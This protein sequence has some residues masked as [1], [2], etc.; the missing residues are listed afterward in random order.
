[1]WWM[2]FLGEMIKLEYQLFLWGSVFDVLSILSMGRSHESRWGLVQRRFSAACC[3]G[4]SLVLK[5]RSRVL[6]ISRDSR[7]V[8]DSLQGMAVVPIRMNASVRLWGRSS[9]ALRA[10]VPLAGANG[11]YYALSKVPQRFSM[12]RSNVFQLSR[13]EWGTNPSDPSAVKLMSKAGF[14]IQVF[15]EKQPEWQLGERIQR[16]ELPAL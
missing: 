13:L 12:H 8:R 7:A 9:P 2:Y 6:L 16:C 4:W 10:V 11:L 1:M 5:C 3:L 15:H 14:W